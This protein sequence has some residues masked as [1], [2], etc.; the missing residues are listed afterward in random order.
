M[1][2][3]LSAITI[4]VCLLVCLRLTSPLNWLQSLTVCLL[5]KKTVRTALDSFYS[6]VP[7]GM[8]QV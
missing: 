7:G 4:K 3:I 6:Q 8:C 2:D 1:S 5:K